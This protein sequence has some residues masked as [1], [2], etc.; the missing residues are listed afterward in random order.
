MR[1]RLFVFP[2]VFFV[3]VMPTAEAQWLGNDSG[4]CRDGKWVQSPIPGGGMG[5]MCVPNQKQNRQPSYNP[6]PTYNQPPTT[7][8]PPPYNPQPTYQPPTLPS[9][10]WQESVALGGM[11]M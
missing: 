4:L 10:V 7:Y 5:A 3:S 8:N 6:P 1:K 9:A 11:I 2:A